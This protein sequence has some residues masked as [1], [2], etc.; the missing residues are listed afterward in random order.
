MARGL[1]AIMYTPNLLAFKN[2]F[3]APLFE[4]V[5]YRVCL[6]NMSLESGALSVNMSVILL[7]FFFA[8]SHLHHICEHNRT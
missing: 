8:I 6:I 1:A 2:L 7:P 4:E 3:A 5:I